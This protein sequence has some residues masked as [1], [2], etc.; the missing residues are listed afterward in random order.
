MTIGPLQLLWVSFDDEQRTKPIVQELNAVRKSGT[1]RLVDMLYV[2]KDPAGELQKKQVSDLA[3]AQKAEY[4]IILQGL[5][6]MRAAYKT[7]GDVD[8]IAAAMSLTPGDFGITSNQVQQMA[9]DIPNGGSA[10]LILFEHLWAVKFK[11]ALLNAGGRLISQGLLS[12]E[13]LAMGGTTVEEAMAAA[14]RIQ[15]QAEQA[16]AAEAANLDAQRAELDQKL[17]DVD[18]EIAAKRA[19][20]ER[21]LAEADAQAAA[22]MEQAKIAAA[23]AIAAGVRTAASEMQRADEALTQSQR[24]AAQRLED[25]DRLAAE[26]LQQAEREAAEQLQ[27]AERE[28]AER[29][30]AS[31]RQAAAAVAMGS[32][33]AS[34]KIQA[35]EQVAQQTIEDGIQTAEAIKSAAAIEAIRIL[36]EAQLIKREAARQALLTLTAA[37]LIQEADARML[38]QGT[39]PAS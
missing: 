11:E 7:G 4:G 37:A 26:Q 14:K 23:A 8:Q 27:Q 34:G 12:P 3:D 19:E 32:V 6:G 35:G 36:V 5:L 17:V 39:R 30:D 28:A 22:R 1:I 31:Q 38:M 16:A 9:R 33:I 18:A 13:A 15:E 20:A 21:L 29:L 2:Y 24:E 25:A 10:I